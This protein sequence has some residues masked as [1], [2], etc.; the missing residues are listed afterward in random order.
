LQKANWVI[1]VDLLFVNPLI[2]LFGIVVLSIVSVRLLMAVHPHDDEQGVQSDAAD[3]A[4]TQGKTFSIL[5]N[6]N[7]N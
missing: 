3:S 6:E 2:D 7:Y 1:I 4:R 5:K